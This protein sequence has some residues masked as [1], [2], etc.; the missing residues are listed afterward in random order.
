MKKLVLLSF[1]IL[2]FVAA[3]GHAVVT[4]NFQANCDSGIPTDCVL[5]PNRTPSGQTAT[6]CPAGYSVSKYFVD[7]GDGTSYFYFPPPHQTSHTFSG[8]SS[9]DICLTVFCSNGT[10]TVSTTTCHC[11]SNTLGIG[12]CVRP[13]AGWT[14]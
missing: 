7:W 11:F 3:A 1:C 4:A 6:S 2:G 10:T 8:A 12:G 5:D 13:G 14:P 9:N